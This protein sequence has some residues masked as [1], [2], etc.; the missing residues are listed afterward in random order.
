M[1]RLTIVICFFL[2]GFTSSSQNLFNA[3]FTYAYAKNLTCRKLYNESNQSIEKYLHFEQADSFLALYIHNLYLQ[4]KHRDLVQTIQKLITQNSLDSSV[5]NQ[6]A[7]ICFELDSSHLLAPIKQQ[8]TTDLLARYIALNENTDSLKA[9]IETNSSTLD[10]AYFNSI[11]DKLISTQV[12]YKNPNKYI[13]A[14][15]LLPG[16]GKM[17]LGNSYEGFWHSFI[18]ASHVYL[19]IYSFNKAGVLSLFA[20]LNTGMAISF[21]G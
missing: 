2:S 18:V 9:F 4:E 3:E 21:Y 15:I 5:L 6:I 19:S 20:W 7:S 17:L 13:L 1:I 14:S 11:L 8:L 16:S 12:T 10:T